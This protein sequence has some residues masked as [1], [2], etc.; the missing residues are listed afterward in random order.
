MEDLHDRA[1]E[2]RRQGWSVNDIGCEGAKAKP[3]RPGEER[4]GYINSDPVL[5]ELF[6][7]FLETLGRPR[8]ELRYRASAGR[9]R[10]APD[11]AGSRRAPSSRYHGSSDRPW[12]NW[13]HPALWRRFS[14][15]ES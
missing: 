15:F 11:E 9:S 13:Q 7:R 1:T 12:C 5:I 10:P 3:W 14:R 8:S 4:L 2:L 6:L